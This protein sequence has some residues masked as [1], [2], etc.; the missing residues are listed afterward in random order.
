M[1]RRVTRLVPLLLILAMSGCVLFPGHGWHDSH[2][3]HE[4]GPGYYHR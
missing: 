4:G 1:L 2:R 3:H